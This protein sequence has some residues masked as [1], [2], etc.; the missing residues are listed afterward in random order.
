[1]EGRNLSLKKMLRRWF[2]F[3]RTFWMS[4][5]TNKNRSVMIIWTILRSL[6]TV[7]VLPLS[8]SWEIYRRVKFHK[9]PQLQT[10]PKENKKQNLKNRLNNFLGLTVSLLGIH[11]L[12]WCHILS[13]NLR[14][15]IVS[16]CLRRWWSLKAMRISSWWRFFFRIE[17]NRVSL[18]QMVRW[19]FRKPTSRRGRKRREQSM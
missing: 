3:I 13:R 6:S 8:L 1:M 5:K 7:D 16:D 2:I 11:L 4:R 19:N 10:E 12:W 14:T 17:K 15:T 9:Y 18:L